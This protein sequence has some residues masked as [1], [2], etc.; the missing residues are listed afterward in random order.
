VT[1]GCDR[2]ALEGFVGGDLEEELPRSPNCSEPMG[3]HWE[4]EPPAF[5]ETTDY[6]DL[7]TRIVLCED[8]CA[9][10]QDFGGFDDFRAHVG[11]HVEPMM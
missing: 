3:W 1:R 6:E 7:C 2:V 5:D 10:L 4:G 11:H 9:A 8:A